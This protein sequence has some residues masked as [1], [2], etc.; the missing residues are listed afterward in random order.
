ML[1]CLQLLVSVGYSGNVI[2][3][4]SAGVTGWQFAFTTVGQL[5]EPAQVTQVANVGD[6]VV[7]SSTTGV[8]VAYTPAL[9]ANQFHT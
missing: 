3:T 7:Y 2:A 6:W 8:A 1:A 5:G 9:F 4:T